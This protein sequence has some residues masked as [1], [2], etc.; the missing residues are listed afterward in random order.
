MKVLFLLGK[1]VTG[2]HSKN[3]GDFA[4][5]TGVDDLVD[6]DGSFISSGE[7]QLVSINHAFN[8][9]ANFLILDEATSHIDAQIELRVRDEIK[10]GSK[11]RTTLIIAHRLANVRD[12]DKI[13]VIHK[14]QVFE[15]GTHEELLQKQGIYFN[16]YQLQSEISRVSREFN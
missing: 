4:S 13:I 7:R 3:G 2:G 14:G 16:L 1:G 6:G 8:R 9:D 5:S 15:I 11:K 10:K 12:A